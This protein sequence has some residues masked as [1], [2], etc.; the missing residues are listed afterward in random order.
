M[1]Y[2]FHFFSNSSTSEEIQSRAIN[3][4]DGHE[5]SSLEHQYVQRFQAEVDETAFSMTEKTAKL[6]PHNALPSSSIEVVEF[7]L[8]MASNV[9]EVR[10]II[11]V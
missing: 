4:R 1:N 5:L 6:R 2:T 9:C 7:L 8:N 11:Q 3:G 10:D